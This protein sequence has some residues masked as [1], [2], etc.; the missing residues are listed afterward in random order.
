MFSARDDCVK[1]SFYLWECPGGVTA[2]AVPP[3]LLRVQACA[4]LSFAEGMQPMVLYIFEPSENTILKA[5][6]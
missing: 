4:P 1:S 3:V 2:L 5:A 6:V